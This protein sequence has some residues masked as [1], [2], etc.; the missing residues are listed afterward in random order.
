LDRNR[1]SKIFGVGPKGALISL[2][3]LG[4]AVGIDSVIGDGAITRCTT[5]LQATGCVLIGL[6]LGLHGWSF[7]ALRDW[8]GESRLCTRGPFHYF[9]HPMYAAWITFIVPGI[10]LIL[11]AWVYLAWVIVLH[12]IWHLMVRGEEQTMQHH[13]GETYRQYAERTR[14]FIPRFFNR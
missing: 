11:N 4:V 14:R 5:I 13:F 7:I 10:A 8:W 9:R 1:L 6:G 2:G 3:L 12:P